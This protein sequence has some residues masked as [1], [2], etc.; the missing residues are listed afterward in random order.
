M[1]PVSGKKTYTIKLPQDVSI[2]IVRKWCID[3]GIK[4]IG[5]PTKVNNDTTW[6]FKFS[7]D[8]DK[9]LFKLTWG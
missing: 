1:I 2:R 9:V 3:N 4:L 7:S 8:K 6:G 5:V